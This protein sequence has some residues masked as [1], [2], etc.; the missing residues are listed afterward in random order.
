MNKEILLLI[1]ICKTNKKEFHAN[2]LASMLNLKFTEGIYP[3]IKKLL[4]EQLL[5]KQ[6]KATYILNERDERVQ[7]IK[8]LQNL[9]GNNVELLLSIHT[10]NILE[11][12][13]INPMLKATDLPYHNL[14]KIKE[15]AKKTRIIYSSPNGSTIIYF[16]RSWEE[17][18]LRLL[19]FFGIKIQF[20]EEEFKHYI[21]KTYSAFTGTQK[22]LLDERQLEL[23]KLNM[24]YY[25]QKQDYILNK[26]FNTD[27]HETKIL[28]ILTKEK[29]KKMT[30]PFEITRKIIEW[31]IRY[32]YNTDKIEGN[33]LTFEEVKTGLTEGWEGIK[34]E[35]KDI[36]ETENSKKAIE[37]IFDTTNE[38]TID[39]I[40][41]LHSITQQG[42]DEN[43]GQYKQE[44]NCIT[45]TNG[46]LI[47]N[48]TPVNFVEER[49]TDLVK[50]YSEKKGELHPVVLAGV[51][52]NQ[53]VYIHPFS[54]GNGRVARLILNFIL[55]KHGYFP[56]IIMNDEKQKYYIALRQSKN[57]DIK[58]F[59]YYLS[60]IYRIQLELF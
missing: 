25:L 9:Y 60:D 18:V 4:D 28:E 34:R 27:T 48:T 53:F 8:F 17:P 42:I 1:K 16:I 2:E 57:G 43:A 12:F 45:D 21:I 5:A 23:S 31:K 54:D 33:A 55:I 36:L 14:S 19:S 38:L 52:H 26:L 35:K 3:Y 6:G 40:K 56:V 15:I 46:R 22:H 49:M 7:T 37:N 44:E 30:N 47:D 24:N 10:K 13:S 41:K 50:W 11:K 51:V 39:F 32:V 29:I 59:V 58:P 20:D